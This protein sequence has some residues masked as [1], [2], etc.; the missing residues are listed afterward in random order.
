MLAN[1][2]YSY[3]TWIVGNIIVGLFV[4]I[5][6]IGLVI[7]HHLVPLN[8]RR[9][10]NDLV[11]F[12]IAVVGVV[13]A[14][15]LAFIAVTT[16]ETFRKGDNVVGSEASYAGDIFRNTI[17]LPDDIAE[18]L[19][20]HLREYI[21]V[22]IEQEWPAQQA[23]RLEESS[24]KNGWNILDN[25]HIDI[26]RFRPANAGETVVQGQLLRGVNNL[27]DARRSRLLAAEEHVTPVIWW[28]IAFGAMLTVSS[29]YL[30][31][32]PNFKMHVVITAMLAASLAVVI[33]LIVTL[34]YPFRGS[35]SI[36]DEAFRHVRKNMETLVFQRR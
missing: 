29:T 1:W 2:I 21:D 36:S 15:L 20:G 10:H 12:T 7:I 6:C 23:G 28:I 11:G 4:L 13:F 16:W 26:A 14:V 17:G 8:I 35:L 5:S 25:I 31:G 34:D 18:R 22:V 27:Y 19:R 33:V 9:S 30:F 3:P 24:W 32:P